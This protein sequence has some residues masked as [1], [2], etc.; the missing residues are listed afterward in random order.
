MNSP[1]SDNTEY[2]NFSNIPNS[3]INKN[4][5]TKNL[6]C[7]ETGQFVSSFLSKGLSKK[8]YETFDDALQAS[9]MIED[10]NNKIQEE[11]D[12]RDKINIFV[13][14][15]PDKKE[16]LEDSIKNNNS[17]KRTKIMKTV[18]VTRVVAC[19][20][21]NDNNLKL[22]SEFYESNSDN[23][24]QTIIS[25]LIKLCEKDIF[26]GKTINICLQSSQIS[27]K[28]FVKYKIYQ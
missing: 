8:N 11:R 1:I 22:L 27:I 12:G 6:I 26:K 3:F 13:G 20:Y 25:L 4:F 15:Y 5:D 24:F 2:A 23:N 14:L 28:Y 9:Q 16:I 19:Y 18:R 10:F 17:K 21:D 7:I